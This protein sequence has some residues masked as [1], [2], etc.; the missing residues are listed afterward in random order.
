MT[1]IRRT[2]HTNGGTRHTT[3][4]TSTGRLTQST[5]QRTGTGRITHTVD[6]EGRSYTTRTTRFADGSWERERLGAKTPVQNGRRNTRGLQGV[7][8]D[9][10]APERTGGPSDTALQVLGW[11]GIVFVVLWVLGLL[12]GA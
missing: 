12:L 4:L 11:I 1:R 7:S 9:W 6:N 8:R 3:T 2:S 10:T 5:S